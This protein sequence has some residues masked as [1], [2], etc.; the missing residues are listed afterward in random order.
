MI[1]AG[2]ETTHTAISQSM[3]MYLEDPEIAARTDEAVA[4]AARIAPS[5]STSG[6]S[7]WRCRW[8]AAPP[9][10]P[11]SLANPFART[12]SWS[13]YYIA[14]NRDPAVFSDPDRFDPQRPR[15]PRHWPSAKVYTAA[16]AAHL[17]KL[18]LTSSSGMN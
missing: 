14:A 8:R 13:T 15:E 1:V 7:A 11:N 17:A 12:T 6:S 3:R 9:V 10:I 18:E 2:F 16:S 5:M 4:R